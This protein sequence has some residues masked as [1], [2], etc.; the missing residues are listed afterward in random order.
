MMVCLCAATFVSCGDDDDDIPGETA[1]ET[2]FYT[3]RVDVE[4]EGDTKHWK[5][6]VVFVAMEDSITGIT[7]KLF[8]NGE[9]KNGGKNVWDNP[10]IRNYSVYTDENCQTLFCMVE[11]VNENPAVK[12]E[13]ITI[14]L[15]GYVN[16]KLKKEKTVVFE[17]NGKMKYIFF[18]NNK[19][20]DYVGEDK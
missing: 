19:D 5:G 11:C 10:E 6:S 15:K 7:G 16:G 2:F 1:P 13:P 17:D 18:Y 3:H 8:E 9:V 12:L 4:F 14:K 20:G